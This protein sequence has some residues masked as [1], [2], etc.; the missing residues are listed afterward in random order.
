VRRRR[1]QGTAARSLAHLAVV[2]LVAGSASIGV[3]AAQGLIGQDA[4]ALQ[5]VPPAFGAVSEVAAAANDEQV[6]IEI[7]PEAGVATGG[8]DVEADAMIEERSAYT[9]PPEVP[10]AII[11]PAP[12]P[13]VRTGSVGPRLPVAGPTGFV[14]GDGSL[15][16]P[17]PGGYVSQY[18][19]SGHTGLDIANNYGRPVVA[20]DT[21]TVTQAGWLNTGG[22]WVVTIAHSNGRVT[23]YNHLG[24]IQVGAGQAVMRGQQIATVGCSGWCTGPHVHFQTIVNGVVVNPLRFL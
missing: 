8:S 19:W 18:F 13:P 2:A 12:P 5:V 21:G 7:E 17:V 16:W 23:V 10:T 22:G 9:P 14:N 24:S 3:L 1:S 11:L 6:A 4:S 20:A 15:L